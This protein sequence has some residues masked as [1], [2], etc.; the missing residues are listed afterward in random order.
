MFTLFIFCCVFVGVDGEGNSGCNK[1][2]SRDCF[3]Y[4]PRNNEVEKDSIDVQSDHRNDDGFSSV[5]LALIAQL[6]EGIP[7][8]TAMFHQR[9]DEPVE[10]P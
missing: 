9:S 3:D 2:Y 1:R 4:V 8:N 10:M 6:L 5:R 7:V